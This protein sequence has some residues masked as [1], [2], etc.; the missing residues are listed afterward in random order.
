VTGSLSEVEELL[1]RTEFA[2]ETSSLVD[3]RQWRSEL[4]HASVF[5]SYA[6]G[7]LS[8]DD[9]ILQQ[10]Y[11]TPGETDLQS[12][13]DDLPRLLAN[14]WIGG[15][16]S[17]SPDAVASVTAADDLTRDYAQGLLGL[18]AKIVSSDLRD[19]QVVDELLEQVK[20]EKLTLSNLRDVMERR[21]RDIQ[22]V[23]LHHYTTGA[24]SIDDWLN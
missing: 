23:V 19:P 24:A 14:G 20:Q 18:H 12:L 21:I 5:V 1:H 11:L 10:A 2:G 22:A 9:E 8:L 3:L 15:G 13:V 16:W 17:L 6:L 7:V 4:V